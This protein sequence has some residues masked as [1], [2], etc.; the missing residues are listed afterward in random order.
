MGKSNN[1]TNVALLFKRYIWLV[2]VISSFGPIS[3]KEINEKWLMS[4]LNED[5][6]KLPRETFIRHK[7]AIQ[8]M[9]DIDICCNSRHQYYIEDAIGENDVKGIRRLLINAMSLNGL[10]NENNHVNDLILV[11]DSYINNQYVRLIVESIEGKYYLNLSYQKF[12]SQEQVYV[13]RPLCIKIFRQRWY[14][15]CMI[16]GR[17]GI[18]TL[19]LERIIKITKSNIRFVS[20][21]KFDPKNYFQNY[22]GIT[23]DKNIEPI[24]IE[25]HASPRQ[26]EYLRTTPIHNSQQEK[27]KS[28]DSVIFTYF[29]APT[30]EFEMEILRYSK[31]LKVVSPLEFRERIASVLR[32]IVEGYE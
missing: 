19:G 31:E 29:V 32:E 7:E 11:E 6:L 22:F 1:K 9:F 28:G 17:S 2:D 10:V 21:N 23:V 26:A 12:G 4:S 25:V 15:V 13:I 20:D 30:Y 14:L 8:M 3:L 5:N 24:L 18:F 16:K 27:G